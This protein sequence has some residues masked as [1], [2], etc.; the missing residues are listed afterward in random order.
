LRPRAEAS[1][2]RVPQ[3][4]VVLALLAATAAASW[5]VLLREQSGMAMAS[6]PT[7]GMP[8]PLFLS[9]WV[10][11]MIAM[12]FPTAAPMILTFHRVQWGKRAR[13]EPFV[14]TWVFVAAYLLVW[15]A[16]GV[17][18]YGGALAAEALA[19][20]AHLSAQAAARIGGIV[21]LL[22]GVYQLSPLK[23][24]C[25]AKCRS[26]L[27]FVLTAWRDG[28]GGALRMGLEHGGYCL[29]CCWLL[30]VMLFPLGTMNVAAMAV[31]TL[32][33]FA[34]KSLGWG[35][36]IASAAGIALVL[37]GAIVIAAPRALPTFVPGDETK[38]TMPASMKM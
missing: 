14:S 2:R 11:M 16:A 26:P 32:L 8:A 34:E 35:R 6:T 7:M 27:T 33:I 22:A 18:A 1:A 19:A 12:M 15:T 23:N 10:V 24:V 13:S 17:V 36:R 25:L 4:N 38:M 30:F 37:Y 20:R 31:V 9:V 29:G 5:I 3:A 21:L 28:T